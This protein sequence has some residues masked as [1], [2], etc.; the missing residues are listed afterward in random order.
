M[1]TSTQIK[2]VGEELLQKVESLPSAEHHSGELAIACGYIKE[3]GTP[4]LIDYY[5]E[6]LEA[7][8]ISVKED[9][10]AN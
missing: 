5:T 8:G 6:L 2:L 10:Q 3:D 1:I 9:F 7:K 4:N